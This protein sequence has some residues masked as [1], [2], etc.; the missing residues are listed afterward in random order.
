MRYKSATAIFLALS[1]SWL[2]GS[3]AGAQTLIIA[4]EDAAPYN[5]LKQGTS[6]ITGLATELLKK[7]LDEA[8]VEYSINIYPW[9]RAYRAAQNDANTCVYSTTRTEQREPLFKWIGPLVKNEWVLFGREGSPQLS[10][11]DDAKSGV[12][13]GYLDDAAT[14]YV[15]QLGL[16]VEEAPDDHLN[17]KKLVAKRIDYWVNGIRGGK[18]M[19]KEA[20]IAGLVPVFKLKDV[21]LSLAC[22]KSVPDDIV[23]K[24]NTIIQ[25]MY[26]D[27]T[28]EAINKKYE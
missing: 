17:L 14:S 15:K 27:G 1:A 26:D 20:G 16:K 28:V 25:K 6:E 4:T 3:S 13:G 2:F 18:Y 12:I 23:D 7:A 9:A 21:T 8:K 11:L 10:S 24:L 22:N 19:A 5:M